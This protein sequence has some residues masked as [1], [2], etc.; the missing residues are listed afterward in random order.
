[1]CRRAAWSSWR[2]EAARRGEKSRQEQDSCATQIVSLEGPAGEFKSTSQSKTRLTLQS[3]KRL[4]ADVVTQIGLSTTERTNA[5]KSTCSHPSLAMLVL[6]LARRLVGAFPLPQKT[7]LNAAES[8]DHQLASPPPFP[9]KLD[10]TPRADP[11]PGPSSCS[12]NTQLTNQDACYA[13]Q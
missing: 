3:V 13:R 11:L 6:F 9:A 7:S 4:Q 1:M 8:R 10:T 12:R 5:V 2:L